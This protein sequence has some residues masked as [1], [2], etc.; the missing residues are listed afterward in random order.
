M[1]WEV[2]CGL[3]RFADVAGNGR[4]KV[5]CG[6]LMQEKSSQRFSIRLKSLL[7]VRGLLP[8]DL[9]RSAGVS[10]GYV[11]ALLNE[12]KLEPSVRV[13]ARF[14]EVLQCD[15]LWLLT[16]RGLS[17]VPEIDAALKYQIEETAEPSSVVRDEPR[18]PLAMTLLDQL[19]SAVAEGGGS[20]VT[21]VRI[22]TALERIAGVFERDEEKRKKPV[23]YYQ[24]NKKP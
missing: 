9:A 19:R 15:S 10:K 12:T 6:S 24:T 3:V 14:A 17:G 8:I 23:S 18:E 4:I 13:S 2:V 1:T 22:A 20:D 11:S 16:G 21:L 5:F 7:T